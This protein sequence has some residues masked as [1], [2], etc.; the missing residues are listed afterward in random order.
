M[1]ETRPG[2]DDDRAEV[3]ERYARHGRNGR[4]QTCRPGE[5][6]LENGLVGARKAKVIY[7]DRASALAAARELHAVGAGRMSAY[8]CLRSKQGHWHL[9]TE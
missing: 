6:E 8:Q 7:P 4:V 9:T 1:T 3:L 5:A 2:S